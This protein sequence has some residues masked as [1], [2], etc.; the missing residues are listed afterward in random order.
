MNKSIF[1]MNHSDKLQEPDSAKL[2]VD[3]DLPSLHLA[4]EFAV[5]ADKARAFGMSLSG[6][7]YGAKCAAYLKEIGMYCD[8]DWQVRQSTDGD[9]DAAEL[10]EIGMGR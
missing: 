6:L 10:F 5:G 3:H 7:E 2:D 9:N 8:A 4:L 1:G